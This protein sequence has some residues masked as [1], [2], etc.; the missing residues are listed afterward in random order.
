MTRVGRLPRI[1]PFSTRFVQPGAIPFRFP[2]SDALA[3]LARSGAA[4]ASE[5]QIVGLGSPRVDAARE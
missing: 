1:N 3:N 2:T 4:V 5:G